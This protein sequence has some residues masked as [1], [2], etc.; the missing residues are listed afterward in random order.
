[1]LLAVALVTGTAAV[2]ASAT[3]DC[4]P[5]LRCFDPGEQPK[6]KALDE[7]VAAGVTE[8]ITK[9]L[10][11]HLCVDPKKITE[12][13]KLCDDLKID[14]LD[15]IELRVSIEVEFVFELERTVPP[16]GKITDEIFERLLTVGDI[17]RY[18][19]TGI[20]P[21]PAKGQQLCKIKPFPPKKQTTSP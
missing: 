13:T 8:R 19:K 21:S 4:M 15:Q 20:A 17:S 7:G 5:F 16:Y 3:H 9:V 2:P 1:L 11:D 6:F 14:E 18:I 10:S 12:N